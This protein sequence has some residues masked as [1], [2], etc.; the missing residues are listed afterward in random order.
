MRIL[1]LREEI[2]VKSFRCLLLLFLGDEVVDGFALLQLF[3]HF[4][5]KFDTVHDPLQQ[6][7]LTETQTIGVGDVVDSSFSLSI[8]TTCFGR[9]TICQS[10]TRTSNCSNLLIRIMPRSAGIFRCD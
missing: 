5:E 4:D 3:F 6:L 2:P 8:H 10:A 7:Y 1:R 9:N